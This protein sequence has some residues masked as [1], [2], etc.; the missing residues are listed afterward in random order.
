LLTV[1]EVRRIFPGAKAG[2]L[3]R[4]I[5]GVDL[6]RCAWEHSGGQLIILSGEEDQSPEEEARSFADTFLDPLNGAAIK[7]VRFE[8]IAGVGDSAVAVV[9]HADKAKGFM[10][11][12]AY[13][14]VRR[15]KS[16]VVIAPTSMSSRERP[17]VLTALT[18]LGKAVAGRLR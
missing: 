17:A 10:R 11:D 7:Q 12:G 18:E 14:V 3:E 16:Q 2:K 5:E 9:E 13:I 1:D 8:K 6:L 4:P 15:G